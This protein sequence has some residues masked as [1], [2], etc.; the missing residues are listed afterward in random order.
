MGNVSPVDESEETALKLAFSVLHPYAEQ[1]L[2]SKKFRL[3]NVQPKKIYFSGGFGVSASWVDVA[4]YERA[5]PD[6]LA[7]EVPAVL[8]RL[9]TEKKGELLLVCK[10]FLGMR[11]STVES[12]RVQAIDRLGID[13]RV[14]AGDFTDEY[15]VGFRHPASSSEDVKSE[16]LKLFLEAWER[17]QGVFDQPG[18]KT[19]AQLYRERLARRAARGVVEGE[20]DD[21]EEEDHRFDVGDGPPK[22]REIVVT[23]QVA[24]KKKKRRGRKGKKPEEEVDTLSAVYHDDDEE[25]DKDHERRRRS[26]QDQ[27]LPPVALVAPDAL[28]GEL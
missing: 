2:D 15:R 24:G 4:A 16:M 8:S 10:H 18:K 26:G 7:H 21:E 3:Y 17:E 27:N 11:L 1:I 5:K 6:V 12:V 28:R 19:P 20:D 25:E 9:N 13:I 22:P 23:L 14:K